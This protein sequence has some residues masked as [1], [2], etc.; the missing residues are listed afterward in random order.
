[1]PTVTAAKHQ[2]LKKR[3]DALL[4]LHCVLLEKKEEVKIV[5]KAH[6]EMKEEVK[7]AMTEQNVDI[8]KAAVRG[9]NKDSPP[10]KFEMQVYERVIVPAVNADFL[11]LGV[12][13][14]LSSIDLTKGIPA[15]FVD[16]L[17]ASLMQRKK[18]KIGGKTVISM[19]IRAVKEKKEPKSRK[20]K[21]C[22][23]TIID[24]DPPAT[25]PPLKTVVMAAT[26][27][28]SGN[29]PAVDDGGPPPGISHAQL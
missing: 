5:R 28:S 29:P 13:E 1:M 19:T 2:S 4:A 14:Y 26:V 23:E 7:K 15:T 16:D 21:K 18:D 9:K 12:K 27:T 11:N 22:P 3:V 24:D 25:P 17:T 6:K 10:L 20:R 8:I